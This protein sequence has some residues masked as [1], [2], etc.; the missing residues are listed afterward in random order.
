MY[1][2]RLRFA[3][4]NTTFSGLKLFRNRRNTDTHT[5]TPSH[6]CTL[7]VGSLKVFVIFGKFI[8]GGGLSSQVRF[9]VVKDSQEKWWRYS[10]TP[11]RWEKGVGISSTLDWR[12]AEDEHIAKV[13]VIWP[14]CTEGAP[15]KIL[16]SILRGRR[17][18]RRQQKNL[19][20]LRGRR[21]TYDC[22]KQR[23]CSRPPNVEQIFKLKRKLLQ[24]VM[25]YH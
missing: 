16:K 13:E 19:D 12:S 24:K 3:L 1:Q 17:R 22:S 21:H 14:R 7:V 2:G 6:F 25:K 11:P 5:F 8:Q 18:R 15:G 23:R 4:Q 20:Q 9:H 10:Y